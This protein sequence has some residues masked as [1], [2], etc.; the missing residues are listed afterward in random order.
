MK[1]GKEPL[2]TFGDLLQFYKIQSGE[3]ELTAAV[4][5]KKEKKERSP[6]PNQEPSA[7]SSTP[8]SAAAETRAEMK[9]S[10]APGANGDHKPTVD[11]PVTASSTTSGPS[12]E[13]G[14]T[15]A[16]TRRDEP[17]S[18]PTGT[19]AERSGALAEEASG[20]ESAN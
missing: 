12:P 8:E 4:E 13:T 16:K 10:T 3:T 1:A 14:P 7:E 20:S 15:A 19:H 5:P 17:Q 9:S 6:K 11:E 2:R 18:A